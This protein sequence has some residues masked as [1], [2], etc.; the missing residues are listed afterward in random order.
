MAIN[1]NDDYEKLA[2]LL[3]PSIEASGNTYYGQTRKLTLDEVF[4]KNNGGFESHIESVR[5]DNPSADYGFTYDTL[6]CWKVG[7]LSGTLKVDAEYN[8]GTYF[9]IYEIISEPVTNINQLNS[10]EFNTYEYN[11]SCE[12]KEVKETGGKSPVNSTEV[13]DG[14]NFYIYKDGIKN[15]IAIAVNTE[16]D[17]AQYDE[18]NPL[19]LTAVNGP[20]NIELFIVNEGGLPIIDDATHPMYDY[21]TDDCETWSWCELSISDLHSGEYIQLNSG[22][23]AYFR[24][25][26]NAVKSFN[27]DRF[28]HFKFTGDGKVVASG[29]IR[30]MKQD[31]NGSL[32]FCEFNRLFWNCTQLIKAPSLPDKQ[33]A[34]ACY[35]DMFRGCTSL[36]KTPKLIASELADSCYGR[37][38]SGCTSL[39]KVICYASDISAQSSTY[40]WLRNVANA[41]EF[42]TLNGTNWQTDSED[43]IPTGWTR[44]NMSVPTEYTGED[45]KYNYLVTDGSNSSENGR[46]SVTSN[47]TLYN[48]ENSFDELHSHQ[49][50]TYNADGSFNQEIWGYKCFNSPVQFKNGIY[51]EQAKLVTAHETKD[52][53]GNNGF[54]FHDT[55]DGSKLYAD[56]ASVSVLKTKNV[57]TN[58]TITQ[59]DL[60][61]SSTYISAGDIAYSSI[62]NVYTGDADNS[63]HGSICATTYHTGTAG[64]NI[65]TVSD[66]VLKSCLDNDC[67][68][69]INL[70]SN[71]N[72]YTDNTAT[73]DSK[74][75]LGSYSSNNSSYINIMPTEIDIHGCVLPTTDNTYDFGS[76]NNKWRNIY[77]KNIIAGLTGD[78]VYGSRGFNINTQNYEF[79]CIAYNMP[80]FG[81]IS[82][83]SSSTFSDVN[84]DNAAT[85]KIKSSTVSTSY[86]PS[87]SFVITDEDIAGSINDINVASIEYDSSLTKY[88]F[89]A[90]NI[91][92][93]RLNT[94]SD[95]SIHTAQNKKIVIGTGEVSSSYSTLS[96]NSGA[97]LQTNQGPIGIVSNSLIQITSGNAESITLTPD[98]S[99]NGDLT[100]NNTLKVNYLKYNSASAVSAENI[101]HSTNTNIESD[102]KLKLSKMD[103]TQ[104]EL[105]IAD[106][107]THARINSSDDNKTDCPIGSIIYAILSK[108]IKPSGT[109]VKAGVPFAVSDGQALV[110]KLTS[111]GWASTVAHEGLY[112]PAG[113]YK[114]FHAIAFTGES[115]PFN[116]PV[117]IQRV[118]DDAT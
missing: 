25:N 68:S 15:Y 117:I 58:G 88:V 9:A 92:T 41:G 116:D 40:L 32:E 29:D 97:L 73:N 84:K 83:Y 104:D 20:V 31:P 19:K 90:D 21:S 105:Y 64:S 54:V 26:S 61:G 74:I 16:A 39:N 112:L 63:T 115:A 36:T 99:V 102:G 56:K 13:Y 76:T 30:S 62:G 49:M 5:V 100:V 113:K 23:S 67:Y 17:S 95:F 50:N 35:V 57:L 86:R 70:S 114:A 22:E 106:A 44:I 28:V 75:K 1:R 33:L 52:T 96:L 47:S 94:S 59:Y 12:F 10:G 91:A 45:C 24:L 103:G 51:G 48:M 111:S 98:V 37:M 66:V 60:S 81:D 101:Y 89:K 72:E 53:S 77:T 85:I 11:T 93:K 65:W 80:S 43:G 34:N 107:A 82:I 18:S 8:I 14:R 69:I 110:A 55:W 79:G 78:A 2:K 38:F 46:G 108:N 4:N 42:V 6:F 27:T 87:I 3:Y 109:V 71:K 118:A 7:P